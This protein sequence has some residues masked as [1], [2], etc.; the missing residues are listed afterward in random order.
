VTGRS[1]EWLLADDVEL[2]SGLAL[3]LLHSVGSVTRSEFGGL[4]EPEEQ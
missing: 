4:S 2:L 1:A 3:P